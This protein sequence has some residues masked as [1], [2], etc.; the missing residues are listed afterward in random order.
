MNDIKRTYAHVGIGGKHTNFFT[1]LVLGASL[2]LMGSV[3]TVGHA[4]AEENTIKR[5]ELIKAIVEKS[6]E[7]AKLEKA[8]GPYLDALHRYRQLQREYGEMHSEL[9]RCMDEVSL[10]NFFWS[11]TLFGLDN[12]F[13]DG[14]INRV[15]DCYEQVGQMLEYK[16]E[17]LDQ[18]EADFQQASKGYYDAKTRI[19]EI[20]ERIAELQ[21]ELECED[22]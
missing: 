14:P 21:K 12:L 9:S 5:I 19:C 18:A 10:S 3:F 20:E 17:T 16:G 8:R 2:L 7:V 22:E 1:R 6:H 15:A 4:L 13:G 11:G